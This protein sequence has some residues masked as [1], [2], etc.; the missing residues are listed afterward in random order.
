MDAATLASILIAVVAVVG[1]LGGGIAWFYK[2][3]GQERESTIALRDNTAATTA[4]TLRFDAFMER[5]Q[6]A[7]EVTTAKLADHETRITLNTRDIQ[8]LQK[9]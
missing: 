6:R 1:L 3:G 5:T 4:L 9:D 7:N 8:L 2:R